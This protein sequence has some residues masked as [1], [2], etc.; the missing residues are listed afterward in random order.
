MGYGVV[1]PVPPFSL[2]RMLE[3]PS[4]AAVAWHT[5]PLTGVYLLALFVSAPVWG[6]ISDRLGR[7]KVLLFGLA[8]FSGAMLAFA[9]LPGLEFA[10]GARAL[11]GVFAA[12]VIPTVF[13]LTGDRQARSERAQTFAWL[14]AA[15][16]LGF[17]SGPALSAGLVP[18]DPLSAAPTVAA[19]TLAWPFYVV[20]LL[21]ESVWYGAFRGLPQPRLR[22]SSAHAPRPATPSLPGL[23]ALS[24]LVMFGLGS[25]EVA[26]ALQGRQVLNLG[27]REIGIMFAECSL[28]MVLAQV[29][30]LAPLI[31]RT[32][33]RALLVPALLAMT[34]GLVLLPFSVRYDALLLAVALIAGV[35]GLLIPALAYL[36]SLAAGAGQGATFG[37]QTAVAS[38]GQGVGSVAA[39]WLFTLSVKAPFWI[40]AGLL[41]GSLDRALLAQAQALGVE[42]RFNSRMERIAGQGVLA[43]GPRAADAAR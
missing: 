25:F 33:G 1:L 38:L 9:L 31:R 13:A 30:V 26:I 37:L 6:R 3:Q 17:L 34:I 5:G 24:L 19:D 23:L 4:N 7:R 10:Y 12:A 15:N 27:P 43:V 11:A 2:A 16:A 36:V 32:G 20:A 18:N 14:Y 35:T 39:G 42:V 29:F 41:E 40:T 8:G 22:R 28:I 21:G